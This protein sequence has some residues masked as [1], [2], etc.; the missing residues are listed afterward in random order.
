CNDGDGLCNDGDGLCNDGDGLC[1]DGDGLCRD[2]I[3]RVST[4]NNQYV[5]TE[6]NE[7]AIKKPSNNKHKN[8]QSQGGIT[9]HHNPMLQPNSLSQMMRSFK[10]VCTNQ[11][12]KNHLPLFQW[13]ERFFDHIVRNDK[14][15]K[16][17]QN[18]IIRN[19]Q[20]W[21][22]DRNNEIDLWM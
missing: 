17:I 13:Q 5:S 4:E 22:C 9:G 19:P 3:N 10:S 14:D 20:N 15:L 18:Y 16:R 12:R 21:K 6:N 1:N 11:I 8:Q 7:N 2:A